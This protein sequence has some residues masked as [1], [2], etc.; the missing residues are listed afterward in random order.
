MNKANSF[1]MVDCPVADMQGMAL[2]YAV[3]MAEGGHSLQTDGITWVVTI[4]GKT[5]VLSQGWGGMAYQPSREWQHGGPIIER[6]QI[7]LRMN[8]M[9]SGPDMGM[10]S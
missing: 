9:F 1:E 5:R 10:S 4:D 3:A 6:E 7:G 8:P 2:D